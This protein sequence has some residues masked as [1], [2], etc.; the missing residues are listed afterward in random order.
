MTDAA[1]TDILIRRIE[2]MWRQASHPGTSQA[3]REVFEAKALKLMDEHR[4]TMAMLDVAYEDPLQDFE[5]GAIEGRYAPAISDILGAVAR[6]YDVRYYWRTVR[7]SPTRII[8]LFGFK[9]DCERTASLSRMLIA[10]AMSQGSKFK[11]ESMSDTMRFRRDFLMGFAST[12]SRRL[13]ESLASAYS[14]MSD[15][16]A[17]STALVLVSRKKQVDGEFNKRRYRTS[18]YNPFGHSANGHAWGA[19]AGERASLSNSRGVSA[20]PKA[21]GR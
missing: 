21:L 8:G 12:V 2:K 4:L 5:Y 9:S 14:D 10:D 6:A 13:R 16:A 15:D 3:E 20:P 18:S 19:A 1:T 11:G 17:T 7:N